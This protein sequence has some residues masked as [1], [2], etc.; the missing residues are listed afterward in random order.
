MR[1]KKPETQVQVTCAYCGCKTETFVSS[2]PD[3]LNFCRIHTPGKEPEK[4]CMTDY[5]E[6]KKNAK[7]LQEKK[8]SSLW[9]QQKVGFQNE[10]KEKVL[11]DRKTAIRKLDELKQF[12]TKKK[13]ASFQKRPS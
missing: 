1:R 2:Y 11:T 8:E 4:D 3:Y 13:Q 5:Y 12:L 10:E 9:T 7:T 6:E